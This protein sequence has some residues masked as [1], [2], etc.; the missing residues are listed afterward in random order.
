M[1]AILIP[2]A[3]SFVL[4]PQRVLEFACRVLLISLRKSMCFYNNPSALKGNEWS[5]IKHQQTS[6][7]QSHTQITPTKPIYDILLGLA[8]TGQTNVWI[9]ALCVLL[10]F[11]VS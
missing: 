11:I 9:I 10:V 5:A 8:R 7:K 4:C 6:T 1:S 2:F 3:V